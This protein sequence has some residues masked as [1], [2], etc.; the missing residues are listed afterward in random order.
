MRP[1]GE[2]WWQFIRHTK[3]PDLPVVLL[4]DLAALVGLAL[5]LDRRRARRGHRQRAVGRRRQP[6]DR[7]AARRGR[8]RARHRD[9]QP[10]RSARRPGPRSWRASGAAIEDEPARA[11]LHPPAHR[12]A[13]PRRDRRRGQGRVRP[14]AVGRASW[15][16]RSTRSRSSIR[17]VEPRATLIFVEPDVYR[18]PARLTGLEVRDRARERVARS[19]S[20]R[21]RRTP[22]VRRLRDL[23]RASRGRRRASRRS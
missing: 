13:R 12:S 19:S 21:S 8:G 23:R 5:A 15:P 3:S 1:A 6:R 2:S 17:A 14:R 7:A 16:P 11:A 20:G 22:G 9:G 18:E 4:E 10:A